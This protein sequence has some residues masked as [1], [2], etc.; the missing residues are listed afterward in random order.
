MRVI[1]FGATGMIGQGVLQAALDDAAVTA[2][3]SVTRTPTGVTHAKLT[4]VIHRDFKNYAPLADAL[5][6]WDACLFCLGISSV[7]LDEARY[8]EIT[9]DYTLA[10]AEAVR[11]ASPDARF[12]YISGA[13]TDSTEKGRAM[14]ARVKGRTENA[15]LAMPFARGAFM[16]RPG[17]IQPVG[18]IRSKTPLYRGMYTV[19]GALFPLWKALA[20]GHV[21]TTRELGLAMLAVARDGSAK[22]VLEAPDLVALGRP[23]ATAA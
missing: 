18:G 10:A 16:L 8:T 23:L 12:L 20:P 4:E 3:L 19:L 7:G 17:Y 2:V 11:A 1:L 21:L 9:Y 6:G 22:R 15:L 13:S 5:R 14:W